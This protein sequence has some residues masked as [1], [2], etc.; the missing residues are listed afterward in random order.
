MGTCGKSGALAPRA[1]LSTRPPVL[2][3]GTATGVL[4]TN[5]FAPQTPPPWW[6]PKSGG[7]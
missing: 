5:L 6:A 2:L 3:F 1:S 7:G 4:V